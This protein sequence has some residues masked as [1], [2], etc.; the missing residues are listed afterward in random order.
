MDPKHGLKIWNFC[1]TICIFVEKCDTMTEGRKGKPRHFCCWAHFLHRDEQTCVE[2]CLISTQTNYLLSYRALLIQL[3]HSA[4]ILVFWLVSGISPGL[5][6]EKVLSY[7]LL[8]MFTSEIR[9]LW[10]FAM[11]SLWYSFLLNW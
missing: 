7:H 4:K 11:A 9:N 5:Q 1:F 2:S 6:A 10:F 3:V 8:D